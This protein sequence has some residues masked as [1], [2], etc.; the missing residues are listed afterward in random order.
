MASDPA[1]DRA[2]RNSRLAVVIMTVIILAGSALMTYSMHRSSQQLIASL[3]SA[4]PDTVIDSL[5]LLRHRRDPAGIAK[6]TQLLASPSNDVQTEAA[7]YLG[8]MGKSQSIPHLI[9]ALKSPDAQE[10]HEISLDLTMMTGQDFG[11]KYND[12]YAW[13]IAKHPNPAATRSQ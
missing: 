5:L 4:N 9:N 8:T 1:R 13:W 12:W 2:K 3:D 10:A 6:A 11:T 7:L